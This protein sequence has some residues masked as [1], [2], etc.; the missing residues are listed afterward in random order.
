MELIDTATEVGITTTADL[1]SKVNSG[2][3]LDI[4]DEFVAVTTYLN[5]ASKIMIQM[6]FLI[7]MMHK[8]SQYLEK[9]LEIAQ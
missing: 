2:G 5:G 8:L 4:G 9:L 7:G 6:Q 1:S 3:F